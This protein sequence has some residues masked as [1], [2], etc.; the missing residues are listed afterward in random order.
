MFQA[1]LL[2]G[3]PRDIAAVADYAAYARRRLDDNAWAYLD[4]AAA[5]ELTRGWNR[6]AFDSLALLPRVMADV[7]GGHCRTTLFG[8]ELPCP[9]LLAPVAWQKLFHPDGEL[10]TAYVAAALG[11]GMVLSTLASCSIEEVAAAAGQGGDGPRWFQLY[12]QPE[13]SLNEELIRRAEAA[14]YEAIVFTV[15]ASLNGIRNRE[16]RVGFQL[17]PGIEAV[18]LRRPQDPDDAEGFARRERSLAEKRQRRGPSNVFDDLMHCAP[19]WADLDW[20]LAKTR[21]PVI[22]KGVLHPDDAARAVDQGAAGIVV[23]NHGGRTLDTLPASLDALPAIA[24][25]LGGRVPT[26]LDGGIQRGTDIFKAIALGA[27]AVLIGRPYL[28]A[29]AAAGPFGI[30]HVLRLLQDELEA[31]MALCGVD[32][33]DRIST[34]YLK[35]PSFRRTDA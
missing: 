12:L 26:L 7:A 8:R 2:D 22:V 20:L 31:T 28:H 30:A 25:R 35:D 16:Q 11:V 15:D 23:S 6:R 3:I 4:G 19:T 21:L 32:R 10:A 34:D 14:G 24:Q 29:L 1:P 13:R 18:N 5:D 27:S 9:I 17:P 33:L